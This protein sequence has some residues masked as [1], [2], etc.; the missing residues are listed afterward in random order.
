MKKLLI[1]FILFLTFVSINTYTQT[2][3]FVRTDPNPVHG[4]AD[5]I[6][7]SYATVTNLTSNVIP[8]TIH[9]TNPSVMT[10]WDLVGMCTWQNC[11]AP[12]YYDHTESCS[13]GQ[14]EFDVYFNPH[15]IPG[16][17]SCTVT[18]TYQTTT[19]SQDFGVVADPVGIK[20]ISSVVKEFKLEQNYPNPFN[21]ETKI[22]FS[23]PTSNYIDLRVYDIL[24]R[25]VKTL[26]SRQL[27]AGEYEIEFNA[28]NLSSGMYYYRLQ[29]GDNVSVRKM[30]LV[31]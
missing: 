9:I 8:I 28:D 21:P 3:T 11:Y 24:G 16:N 23:I 19:I 5:T 10:G 15:G 22:A 12:G 13:S 25:E 14:H 7:S 29:S 20:Q 27:N 31:K 30:T 17:G 18:M 26:L 6:I 4:R 1:P 2:F